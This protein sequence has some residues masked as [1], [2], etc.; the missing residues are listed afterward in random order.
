MPM[1]PRISKT[2]LRKSRKRNILDMKTCPRLAPKT[3]SGS[4]P[5]S[6][7]SLIN[8]ELGNLCQIIPTKQSTVDIIQGLKF[9]DLIWA[10]GD[11]KP[12][13]D[14]WLIWLLLGGR[15]CGK[16]RTGAEWIR[17]QVYLG[18]ARRI[19]LVAPSYNDARE[20]MIDGE[21]G[22]CNIG[23]AHER[24]KYISSRRVLEWPNGA[25]GQ[26]F[27]AEDPDGLRGPQFDAAWAD[28][29]CAWSYPEQTLS[30]LR[31][32]LR[33]GRNPK[34]VMTTTPKPLPALRALMAM[35]GIHT[36]RARTAD[37]LF[38]AQTFHRAVQD[39]YGGTRIGR[40]ELDGELLDDFEGSLFPRA[41]LEAALI[42]DVP[43]RFDKT[44]L[45]LDP[46]A[47]TGE[48]ADSCGM[49][50]A[51]LIG[52]GV[53]ARAYILADVTVQGLSPEGWARRAI[54]QAQ[55]FDADYILAEVNQGGDMVQAIINSIDPSM[56]VRAVH[57]TRSKTLRAEP[58][59]ALYEQGRVKHCAV[60]RALEDELARLGSAVKGAK[61]P[62]RADALVW[63]VTELLVKGGKAGRM[64]SI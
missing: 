10:R 16:T 61:S 18:H 4:K 22:L 60:F 19:A 6:L 27:S 5:D 46:P 17:E 64:R 57:A 47:S 34:L 63:A 7:I 2:L 25:V 14:D 62:D 37:N 43:G 54:V 33:L 31:L 42:T 55:I 58:V 59:A 35:D 20:V 40:Q 44:I 29:F 48:N 51:G 38:L 24:P 13:D 49:I 45:A 15:G 21:S 26:V 41:L 39:S 28:E 36:S 1:P 32:A 52:E 11:Q 23:Y 56:P 9:W 53:A 12:P 30:N 3:G 8:S 50:V